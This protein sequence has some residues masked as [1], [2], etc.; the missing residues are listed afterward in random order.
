MHSR[1]R[2]AL[3]MLCL[4]LGLPI[5]VDQVNAQGFA[6]SQPLSSPNSKPVQGERLSDWLLRQPDDVDAF[7]FG[8]S[9]QV[10]REQTIQDSLHKE[11]L[12]Q[13]RLTKAANPRDHDA[14]IRLISLLGATGR[15]PISV[16]DTRW[17][18][19][20]PKADPVLEVDHRVVLPKRPET[21]SMLRLDATVC[22]L[23][24]QP[25]RH[26]MDYLKICEPTLWQAIDRAWVIQPNGQ[27]NDYGVASWNTQAQ[28]ELAPGALLWAPTRG[29]GWSEDTSMLLAQFLAT[30]SYSDILSLRTGVRD[31]PMGVPQ[32]TAAPTSTAGQP[33]RDAIWT[34]NNWGMIG[35]MQTPTA[36]FAKAGEVRFNL[37]RTYPYLRYNVFLQPFDWLEAGF[38]YTDI[39]NKA[40]GE[41]DLSGNQTY[42][43]KSIDFRVRLVEETAHLPQVALG[44]IDFGGTGLFSS[45]FVVAN[46]R[47]GNLDWSLGVGW[48]NMGSSGNIRNPLSLTSKRFDTRGS[49]SAQGGNL[50]TDSFF[51]GPAALFGG[52]QY[53]TPWPNW[54]LKAEYEGNNYQSQPLSNNQSQRTP[55]NLG[56]VYRYH[57]A[58]DVFL[59][60]ERGN[61]ITLGFTLHTSVAKL[62]A[63]KVS[64]P[65]TPA[66][67]YKRPTAEPLWLGTAADISAMSG[68]AVR[69]IGQVGTLLQVHLEGA[70]GVH[71]NERIERIVAVL[72]RDTPA[73]VDTFELLISTQGVPLTERVII[74]EA[75]VRQNTQLEPSSNQP[76]AIVSRQ[77]SGLKPQNSSLL[78]NRPV[79]RFG[80]ALVPS[81]QQNIGG[82]DGFLLFRAGLSVPVQYKLTDSTSINAAVG[83]NILDNFDNFKYD[84]PSNLPR[85]RTN[86]RQYMT[87]SRVNLANL[88]ITHFGQ[89]AANQY[90]SV[91]GGY[92]EAMFAGVGA[93]WLHRPWHSP[94]AFGV[95]I[96]QVQQRNFNQFFGFDSA[97]SQTGYRTLTG[98]A[99]VYWDTGWKSTHMALS[100]GR[101]LAKDLGAT[102]DLS[103]TFENGV[104]V[105]AWITRTNVS[106][107]QFG[108]GSFDKGMYLR[109]P[110]DVMTTT[111]S[112]DSANLVYNPLTRDGGARLNRSFTLFG[113]TTPRS[114][115]HTRFVPAQ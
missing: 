32:F 20:N 84:G 73:A 70:G 75:W 99:T 79:S 13:M 71:W 35:L 39:Q 86:L 100:L 98:H 23:A 17:L 24:H 29:G 77:P 21:V 8:L 51:R 59:G 31:S 19:A 85:V 22:T 60:L 55:L 63:P 68:W 36:R 94:L 90:Y 104:S 115:E 45:E 82:P 26:P 74:R 96:N 15:V 40:Y 41:A 42:K 56:L 97:G 62:H 65:P 69:E 106:A 4:W 113:A 114:K 3:G 101:Y 37:S 49:N 91:Y 57:P 43:D 16:A 76:S 95:D 78:W 53:H 33:P 109:I 110:F 12:L 25:G 10:P 7:P 89:L 46:K 105:G 18:Q 108:E 102:L 67:V 58:L 81:W 30:Q 88:Q 107:E 38:R 83:L 80:Y 11:L 34:S 111:R 93:E 52:L 48:G 1:V 6:S 66:I 50:N 47:W 72:H 9:W 64:D 92:L 14:L 87:E 27:V 44:M 103:R 5:G 61:A 2:F 112:G 54:I 28:D